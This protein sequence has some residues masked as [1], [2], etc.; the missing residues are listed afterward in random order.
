[1]SSNETFYQF[2]ANEQTECFKAQSEFS[3]LKNVESII[4]SA[5]LM[6][7]TLS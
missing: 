2:E 3:N 7:I 6:I 1:M 4:F 5:L